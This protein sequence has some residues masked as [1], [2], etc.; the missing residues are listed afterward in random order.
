MSIAEDKVISGNAGKII[1]NIPIIKEASD[2]LLEQVFKKAAGASPEDCVA[3]NNALVQANYDSAKIKFIMQIINPVM[4]PDEIAQN[5]IASIDQIESDA[6]MAKEMQEEEES[7]SGAG[8]AAAVSTYAAGA[9]STY[10]AAAAPATTWGT[11]RTDM[12]TNDSADILARMEASAK[13]NQAN[14]NSKMTPVKTLKDNHKAVTSKISALYKENNDAGFSEK[15][16]SK[17][18]KLKKEQEKLNKQIAAT[19]VPCG[20]GECSNFV[21]Y[22]H[23]GVR[24]TFCCHRCE[25]MNTHG[26]TPGRLARIN[27]T[28][29]VTKTSDSVQKKRTTRDG[30]P[31]GKLLRDT[32]H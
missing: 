21:G 23:L 11:R 15:R 20:R 19:Q 25:C 17:I 24:Y 28:P 30:L 4:T 31:R 1:P 27:R 14:R 12:S 13:A 18:D 6:K 7:N 26:V 5:L 2:E 8:A 16:Q 29:P 9:V 22:N 32:E 3:I 10:A